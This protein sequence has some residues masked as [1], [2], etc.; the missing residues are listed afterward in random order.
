MLR[1]LALRLAVS[2]AISRN[3]FYS[4]DT[5]FPVASD[6]SAGPCVVL[7]SPPLAA[8]ASEPPGVKNEVIFRC[9]GVLDGVGVLPATFRLHVELPEAGVRAIGVTLD[10]ASEER[11]GVVSNEAVISCSFSSSPSH[12]S[13]RSRAKYRR[14]HDWRLS[15]PKS[16]WLV[17]LKQ[18]VQSDLSL[19][20]L[21]RYRRFQPGCASPSG[22]PMDCVSQIEDQLLGLSPKSLH[23]QFTVDSLAAP[24][25][26]STA[27]TETRQSSGRR[28]R[29]EEALAF[30][31]EQVP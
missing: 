31:G 21:F 20:Y 15:K 1:L 4:L 2:D 26:P 28:S 10:T 9:V 25:P 22:D 17:L 3:E 29:N 18:Q 7:C 11:F 13:L 19:Q 6:P 5:S 24:T 30:C 12:F 27:M 14:M 8:E 16:S 23:S